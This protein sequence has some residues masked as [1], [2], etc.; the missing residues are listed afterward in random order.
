MNNYS[1]EFNWDTF[2]R[3]TNTLRKEDNTYKLSADNYK[4]GYFYNII[5]YSYWRCIIIATYNNHTF[6]YKNIDESMMPHNLHYTN[7][8]YYTYDYPVLYKENDSGE[9]TEVV[10]ISDLLSE[11]ANNDFE[12]IPV[13]TSGNKI[14][15]DAKI[16]KNGEEIVFDDFSNDVL[17][18]FS[19][20][21]S[22]NKMR[23][24]AELPIIIEPYLEEVKKLK[25]IY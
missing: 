23:Y 8:A 10:L 2:L 17:N 9:I 5:C 19:I 25:K 6:V 15:Q 18:S 7:M 1:E 4:I 11:I 16:L 12:Y 14:I 3:D 24:E 22:L 20:R 21:A 13:K